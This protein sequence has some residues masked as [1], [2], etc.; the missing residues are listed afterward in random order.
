VLYSFSVDL[1]RR[2]VRLHHS[3][4]V[5]FLIWSKRIDWERKRE[6]DELSTFSLSFFFLLYEIVVYFS[7]NIGTLS[8]LPPLFLF[9]SSFLWYV[10][11]VTPRYYISSSSCFCLASPFFFLLYIRHSL[12]CCFAFSSLHMRLRMGV[13]TYSK[14]TL[15]L[16]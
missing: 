16:Y 8:S 1:V 13:N 5:C 6:I 9:C 3:W 7:L 2:F 4:R 14:T 11:L 12:I 10:L 15:R